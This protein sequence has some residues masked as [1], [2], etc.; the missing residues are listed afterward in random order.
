MAFNHNFKECVNPLCSGSL[1]VESVSHFFLYRHYFTD[2]TKTLFNELQSV[3]QNILNQSDN[4]TVEILFY[5]SNKFK[6]QQNRS[7][8]KSSIIFIIKSER[9]SGSFI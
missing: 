1:Q 4:E 5:G 9:F 7:I 8:L 2:I 3:D 6:F